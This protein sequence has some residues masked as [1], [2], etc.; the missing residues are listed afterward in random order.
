[1]SRY[2]ASAAQCDPA[3]LPGVIAAVRSNHQSVD[4]RCRREVAAAAERSRITSEEDAQ[5]RAQEASAMEAARRVASCSHLEA[6]RRGGIELEETTWRRG[7][8]VEW[9][10]SRYALSLH[11]YDDPTS[12][13]RPYRPY[14]NS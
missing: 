5:M 2:F 11:A 1:M 8:D 14:R 3:S 9:R 13:Q 6:V 7:A 4:A 12:P 10:Q